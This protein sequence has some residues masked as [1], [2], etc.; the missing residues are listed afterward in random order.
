MKR[1]MTLIAVGAFVLV[2][3][4]SDNE[5][6]PPAE[7]T[8]ESATDATSASTPAETVP[9]TEA[10]TTTAAPEPTTTAAPAPSTNAAPT[11]STTPNEGRAAMAA[12]TPQDLPGWSV[13]PADEDDDDEHSEF[14]IPECAVLQALEDVPGLE[15]DFDAAL[16]SPDGKVELDENVTVGDPAIVQSAFDAFADP[17]TAG[18]LTAIFTSL[19]SQPGVMPEGVT[20]TGIEFAQQPMVGG[21]QAI[22]YL[23]TITVT[24]TATGVSAPI[25]VRF[26]AVR[27]G[28][29]VAVLTTISTPGA[30]PVDA[31]AVIA[32]AGAKLAAAG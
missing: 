32:A 23:A 6:L 2:G 26:D 5:T 22:G 25:G 13:G 19:L 24:G 27:T 8:A 17:S 12:L 30:A 10:P 4:G 15:D 20:M 3:C 21:D 1:A 11:E 28:P 29:A 7:S 18:C 14:D 31:A 9:P 16:V